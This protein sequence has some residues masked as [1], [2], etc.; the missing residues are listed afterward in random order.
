MPYV[1]RNTPPTA[2]YG[3]WPPRPWW[4]VLVC[5]VALAVWFVFLISLVIRYPG[6]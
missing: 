2:P 4:P 3:T 5:A 6:Q 1:D